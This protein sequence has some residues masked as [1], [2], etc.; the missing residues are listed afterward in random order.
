MNRYEGKPFLRL[1]ECF[2]LSAI[3]ALTDEQHA[4]LT[5][6]EPKLHQLYGTQGSWSEVVAAQM[7]FPESVAEKIREI[8]RINSAKFAQAGAQINPEDFAQNFVDTNFP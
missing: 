2:V 6:L 8:W 7:G 1:L 3:D 4:A 5:A